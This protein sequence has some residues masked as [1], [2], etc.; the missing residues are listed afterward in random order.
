MKKV[1]RETVDNEGLYMCLVS[2]V[3][4]ITPI[5]RGENWVSKKGKLLVQDLIINK[6]AAL[7]CKSRSGVTNSLTSVISLMPSSGEKCLWFE[8]VLGIE[9]GHDVGSV[10][11]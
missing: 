7:V 9:D 5:P 2:K 6:V 8:W 10:L 1:E 4:I 11:C 3:D